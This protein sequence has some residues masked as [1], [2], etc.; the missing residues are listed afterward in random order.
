MYKLNKRVTLL[1]RLRLSALKFRLHRSIT[2]ALVTSLSPHS[3]SLQHHVQTPHSHIFEENSTISYPLKKILNS[4]QNTIYIQYPQTYIWDFQKWIYMLLISTG[5]KI[6]WWLYWWWN[7][8]ISLNL[9]PLCLD[10]YW[11]LYII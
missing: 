2:V 7:K 3:P 1:A 8:L 5:I 6:S 9:S 11:S 10:Y 4:I